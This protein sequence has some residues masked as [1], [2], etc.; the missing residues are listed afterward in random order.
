MRFHEARARGVLAMM[1]CALAVCALAVAACG[2]QDAPSTAA[3][4]ASATT[5]DGASATTGGSAMTTGQTQGDPAACATSQLKISLTHTG[6]LAGQAGGY[7]RFTDDSHAT[8]R[9]SGWPVVAG[10]TASGRA[11]TL[12]HARS[13]MFGAWQYSAP[14][15]VVTLRPGDSAYAVVAADDLPVGGQTSCPAPDVRLRVAAPGSTSTVLISAWLPGAGSYLPTCTTISGT[16]TGETS[17]IT[18]LSTL[19]H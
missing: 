10:V 5:A 15:P 14:L 2:S 16:P 13:T 9:I 8:C 3:G 7:L 12:R 11:T 19:P 18:P 17:A 1:V 4:G 6:A